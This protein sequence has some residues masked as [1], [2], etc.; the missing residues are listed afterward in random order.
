MKDDFYGMPDRCPG[1]GAFDKTTVYGGPSTLQ[2]VWVP[3]IES[4]LCAGCLTHYSGWEEKQ[5]PGRE[6]S[7]WAKPACLI[8]VERI[9]NGE[10][11]HYETYG[12]L[13]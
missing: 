4:V 3:A 2:M 1:C 13:W 6:P 9:A 5:V 10:E 11:P 7:G 12:A 8:N